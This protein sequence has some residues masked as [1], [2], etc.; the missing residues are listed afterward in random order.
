MMELLGSE[1]N[2]ASRSDPDGLL[3]VNTHGQFTN[4]ENATCVID[5][6]VHKGKEIT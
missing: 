6:Q 2:P 5:S 1:V 3:G 4:A